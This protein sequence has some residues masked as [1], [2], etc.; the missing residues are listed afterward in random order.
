MPDPDLI[1]RLVADARPVHAM[2]AVQGRLILTVSAMLTIA[3]VLAM[4]GP[5]A[6][7]MTF[8][9]PNAIVLHWGIWAVVALSCGFAAVASAKPEVGSDR[10]SWRWAAAMAALLPLLGAVA[11]MRNPTLLDNPFWRKDIILC[12]VWGTAAGSVTFAAL[13]LWL[14]RGAPVVPERSGLLAGLS[15]GAIGT[16]AYGLH[17]THSDLAH[18]GLVHALPVVIAALIGRLVVPPLLRW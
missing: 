8:A 14:R 9:V 15:A 2:R 4:I 10:Y 13:I 16:L 5:R 11:L 12:T 18:N 1:N 17:C 6:D 3:L 7:L